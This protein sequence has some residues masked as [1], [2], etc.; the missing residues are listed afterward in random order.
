MQLCMAQ[1]VVISDFQYLQ[2][3]ATGGAKTPF[4]GQK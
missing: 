2:N 4:S 1:L 3:S